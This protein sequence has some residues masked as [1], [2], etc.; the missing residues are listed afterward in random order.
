MRLNPL[1]H[2]AAM[3]CCHRGVGRGAVCVR[4]RLR[5]PVPGADDVSEQRIRRRAAVTTEVLG[6]VEAG[7]IDRHHTGVPQRSGRRPGADSASTSGNHA[8]MG[9]W[10][11]R[12]HVEPKDGGRS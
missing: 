9:W 10:R 6:P 12:V 5:G 7:R 11:S 2:S 4:A 1:A 3:L 8:G